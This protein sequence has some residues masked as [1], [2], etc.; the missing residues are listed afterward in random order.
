MNYI[1]PVQL[2]LEKGSIRDVCFHGVSCRNYSF[3]QRHCRDKLAGQGGSRG[4]LSHPWPA[5]APQGP[6][7]P[8]PP[9]GASA[10]QAEPGWQGWEQREDALEQPRVSPA[11]VV[12][13]PLSMAQWGGKAHVSSR[14]GL[15]GGFLRPR[16][17]L[18]AEGQLGRLR[19]RWAMDVNSLY[20]QWSQQNQENI[21]KQAALAGLQNPSRPVWLHWLDLG[22]LGHWSCMLPSTFTVY[23]LHWIPSSDFN[24]VLSHLSTG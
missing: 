8:S 18:C 1:P 22:G 6:G 10:D 15:G 20:S 16:H 7:K 19:V 21:L 23:I 11:A 4:D 13:T 2:R 24:V 9:G 5:G 12:I 14:Q 3:K 17:G